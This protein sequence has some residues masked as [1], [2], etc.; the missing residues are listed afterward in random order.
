MTIS[1]N[2]GN[3]GTTKNDNNGRNKKNNVKKQ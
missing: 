3:D 2:K 1:A